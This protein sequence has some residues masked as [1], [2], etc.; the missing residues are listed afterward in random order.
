[1]KRRL[2]VVV[3]I[4]IAGACDKVAESVGGVPRSQL[5]SW[6]DDDAYE[7]RSDGMAPALRA[8][9]VVTATTKFGDLERG[10]I[11]V[12]KAPP[13]ASTSDVKVLIKRIVGLPEETIE[14][15][16][17]KILINRQPEQLPEPY[18][19]E[20]VPC[21]ESPLEFVP[22]GSYWVLGDNRQDSRDSTFFKSI[23]LTSVVARVTHIYSPKSRRG[24]VR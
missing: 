11:I 15:T 22:A 21:R 7:N 12:F 4:L 1:M 24:E 18:L 13:N 8:G 10:D 19:P 6:G 17:G 16:G 23:P 3:L 2:A 5:A 20:G 9:D 14:C